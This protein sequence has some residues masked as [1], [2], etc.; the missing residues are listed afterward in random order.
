M[1][2]KVLETANQEIFDTLV[3]NVRAFNEEKL[4]TN[5]NTPLTTVVYDDNDELVGGVS[6]RTIY[7]HFMIGVVWVAEHLRGQGVGSKLMNDAET[8][9]RQ[10][11]C[12]GA[13]VDT[14]SFQGIEFYTS[15]GFEEVGRVKN[16]PE[17]HD[18]VFYA[19]DYVGAKS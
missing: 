19:K 1:N 16:F 3:K 15:L 2:Y 11:G 6:G 17:G 7:G 5:D 18:R 13:Q 8:I 14:L 12:Y 9:A 10:R 4:G